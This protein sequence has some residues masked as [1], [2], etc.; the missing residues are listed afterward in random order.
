[1][2]DG[3][4]G[5][6]V[7]DRVAGLSLDS[8]LVVITHYPGVEATYEIPITLDE[9]RTF[10]IAAGA[11]PSDSLWEGMHPETVHEVAGAWQVTVLDPQWGRNDRLWPAIL[12]ALQN[13]AARKGHI[14]APE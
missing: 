14:V 13:P 4:C 9:G 5:E 7:A 3:L 2:V 8:D 10:S 11:M 1:M 12:E 6:D